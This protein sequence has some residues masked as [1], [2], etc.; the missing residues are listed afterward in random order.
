MAEKLRI[1]EEKFRK[2]AEERIL[3]E[4]KTVKAVKTANEQLSQELTSLR[5]K[6]EEQKN[7]NNRFKD[8]S[9]E[10]IYRKLL[11]LEVENER[12]KTKI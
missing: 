7:I 4:T 10:E 9:P 8:K 2:I 12:L 3:A 6:Y 1:D 11:Q 5:M